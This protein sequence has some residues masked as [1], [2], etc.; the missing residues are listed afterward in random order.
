MIDPPFNNNFFWTSDMFSESLVLKF[1]QESFLAS[2]A[3]DHTSV[4]RA[5]FR[6]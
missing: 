5:T 3:V 4:F 1:F 2:P 6:A